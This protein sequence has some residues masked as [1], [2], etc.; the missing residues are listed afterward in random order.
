MVTRNRPI[1]DFLGP[2]EAKVFRR[3]QRYNN[4]RLDRNL[5]T[6]TVEHAQ[7]NHTRTMDLDFEAFYQT[8]GKHALTEI[9]SYY[10]ALMRKML[11]TTSLPQALSATIS[12]LIRGGGPGQTPLRELRRSKHGP[13]PQARRFN[14]H[15]V[16]HVIRHITAIAIREDRLNRRVARPTDYL[17]EGIGKK[18][19]SRLREELARLDENPY[20]EG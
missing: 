1:S 8:T 11:T 20:Y 14:D 6:V 19:A 3:V 15:E 16:D 17:S 13:N 18:R 12:I 9:E 10:I 4:K 5:R 2:E 7:I